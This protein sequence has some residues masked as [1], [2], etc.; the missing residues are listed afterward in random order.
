MS[1][2]DSFAVLLLALQAC[3]PQT[4]VPSQPPR[5][6]V[7][8]LLVVSSVADCYAVSLGDWEPSA[9]PEGKL[10]WSLPEKLELSSAITET[11][12]AHGELAVKS[13]A[14]RAGAPNRPAFWKV[15]ENKLELLWNDR[16]TGI[17]ALLTPAQRDFSGTAETFQDGDPS[18]HRKARLTLRRI[19][20][21]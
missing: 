4:P 7:D 10:F 12:W 9:N 5:R 14:A 8:K 13:L 21:P 11:G 16:F 2:K 20:C 17:S 3:S 6:P 1:R 18:L 19:P 15:H